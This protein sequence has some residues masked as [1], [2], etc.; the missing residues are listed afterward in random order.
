[1]TSPLQSQDLTLMILGTDWLDHGAAV[2]LD[3]V[4]AMGCTGVALA[5]TYHDGRYTFPRNPRRTVVRLQGD[6]AFF[7]PQLEYPRGHSPVVADAC[8][9]R[10]ILSE[11]CQEARRRGLAVDSWVVTLHSD[12]F[13]SQVPEWSCRNAFGDMHTSDWC[14]SNQEVQF[15]IAT[16]LTD[17][18][19]YPVRRLLLEALH[20]RRYVHGYHHERNMPGLNAFDE[21][22]MGLCFCDH[23]MQ[24]FRQIGGDATRLRESVANHLRLALNGLLPETGNCNLPDE[25]MEQLN[26]YSILRASIITDLVKHINQ[27][28]AAS[29]QKICYIDPAGAAIGYGTGKASG[30]LAALIGTEYGIDYQSLSSAGVYILYLG[31]VSDIVRLGKEIDCYKKHGAEH[32]LLGVVV[33]PC[34]P[35]NSST[36]SLCAVFS[37]LQ[38]RGISMVYLYMYGFMREHDCRNLIA[39]LYHNSTH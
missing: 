13:R 39:A 15:Y 20:Y 38:S 21:Y 10:D 23:C 34:P 19:R 32:L 8:D 3:D 37:A 9:G 25:T 11:V 1:M 31:Y 33:R 36:E 2:L 7:V 5:T 28:A 6:V 12:R 4:K 26:R 14:P 29:G 17:I 18:S 30:R 27:I 16:L 22:L 24:V 35:D